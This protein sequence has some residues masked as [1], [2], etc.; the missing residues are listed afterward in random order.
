MPLDATSYTFLHG[1]GGSFLKNRYAPLPPLHEDTPV[2]SAT[3]SPSPSQ[4]RAQAHD[5]GDYRRTRNH[6]SQSPKAAPFSRSAKRPILPRTPP[7]SSSFSR[8]CMRLRNG[9]PPATTRTPRYCKL[10]DSETIV[11][12][13]WRNSLG[14]RG[15][16]NRLLKSAVNKERGYEYL[17]CKTSETFSENTPRACSSA[18]SKKSGILITSAIAKSGIKNLSR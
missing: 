4:F 3:A 6:I 5:Y 7:S 2:S 14:S 10:V 15:D 12:R 18:S 1:R 13:P 9:A 16:N 17:K 8:P 11:N